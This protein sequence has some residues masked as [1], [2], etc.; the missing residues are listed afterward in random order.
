MTKRTK[1]ARIVLQ[2]VSNT[3]MLRLEVTC[4]L[5]MTIGWCWRAKVHY[6]HQIIDETVENASY[7]LFTMSYLYQLVF[8]IT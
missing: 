1:A 7:K 8:D 5:F 3:Q 6:N 4:E 2:N